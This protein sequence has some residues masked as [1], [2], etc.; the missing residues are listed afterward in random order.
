MRIVFLGNGLSL[1]SGHSRFA[2]QMARH[3]LDSG[4]SARI[5]GSESRTT[6][7]RPQHMA[8]VRREGYEALWRERV[9]FAPGTLRGDNRCLRRQLE[10]V[11]SDADIVHVFDMRALWALHRMFDG[12]IPTRALLQFS[13]LPN[14]KLKYIA[15][16]GTGALLQMVTNRTHIVSA[17]MPTWC[18]ARVFRPAHAV[19]CTSEFLAAALLEQYGVPETKTHVVPAGVDDS[20]DGG[21]QIHDRPD[22]I[23]FGWP[24]AHRG[25]LDAA[26]SFARFLCQYPDAQC[27]V[28]AFAYN[29]LLGEG[30][31]I[32]RS[33]KRR[34]A[35]LGVRHA[36]F[37]PDIRS[38]LRGVRAAVLPFRSPFGYAQPPVVVLEAMAAG[39]PVISTD[40]GSVNE[41]VR[42]GENGFLVRRGDVAG[43][44]ECM[45][46]LWIDDDLYAK[47]SA[48]AKTTILERYTLQRQL[49]G[50]QETYERII[51]S[52]PD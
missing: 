34:F 50:T 22:Y 41:I 47:M 17:L 19:V 52:R 15:H 7:L 6:K 38:R 35:R 4:S 45:R 49:A 42:D 40:V 20:V 2:W 10:P 5:V 27:L 39:V 14:L 28:C 1:A 11:L 21:E 18:V 29:R 25:T 12:R 26:R 32:I 9:E 30:T 16:A 43:I 13:S 44:S 31:L 8:L 46:R 3:L 51:A 23:Y 37:L 24:G 48:I 36:G 33:L